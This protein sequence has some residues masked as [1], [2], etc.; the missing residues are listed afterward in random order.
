MSKVKLEAVV[1]DKVEKALRF[2]FRLHLGGFRVNFG[3]QARL[4]K[5][6]NALNWGGFGLI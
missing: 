4:S 5:P 6:E 2:D 1:V 3:F